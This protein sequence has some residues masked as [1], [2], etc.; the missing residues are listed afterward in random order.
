MNKKLP[1]ALFE[2]YRMIGTVIF[3][4]LFSMMYLNLAMPFSPTTWFKLDMS[5]NFVLTIV[6]FLSSL[7]LI[8]GSRL[9]MYFFKYRRPITVL[10]YTLWCLVE[11]LVISVLY[12]AITL[13]VFPL[14]D[15]SKVTI[16]VMPAP[17]SFRIVSGR[18]FIN[19]LVCLVI[20]NVITQMYY[21]LADKNRTLS[22]VAQHN[23]I[24]DNA[25]EHDNETIYTMFDCKGQL[26]LSVR[27]S[28]LYFI[29]SDDNYIKVWYTDA[30]NELT[31]YLIRCRLKTIEENFRGS[32]LQRCHRQYIVNK[33]KVKVFRKEP[34]GW[35]LYL[36]NEA[37]KPIPVTKTYLKDLQATFSSCSELS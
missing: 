23:V 36:D 27:S 20:P 24:T 21:S 14:L 5:A 3:M 35:F 22:I 7:F 15:S 16:S 1:G 33:E 32:S 12:A 8:M 11:V 19:A 30:N 18:A 2:K 4:A 25:T 26:K 28:N 29:E 37:I 17:E 9:V 13:E 6:F 31:A 10:N 34:E